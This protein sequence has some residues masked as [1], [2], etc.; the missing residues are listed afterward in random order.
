[1]SQWHPKT[2]DLREYALTVMEE[3]Y[4][5][6]ERP[7]CSREDFYDGYMAALRVLRSR[8]AFKPDRWRD[9]TAE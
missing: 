9:D 2:D 1:M 8:S 6:R 3:C 4:A 5:N 7:K